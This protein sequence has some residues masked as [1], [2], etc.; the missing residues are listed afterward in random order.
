VLVG[1]A[2][3]GG[4]DTAD[5]YFFTIEHFTEASGWKASAA[6]IVALMV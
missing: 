2:A 6:G 3:T 4:P 5:D 1:P